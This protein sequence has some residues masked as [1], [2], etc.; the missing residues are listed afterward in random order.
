MVVIPTRPPSQETATEGEHAGTRSAGGATV[1]LV[2]G[3]IIVIIGVTL[4]FDYYDFVPVSLVFSQFGRLALPIIFILIGGALL[5]GRERKVQQKG[6]NEAEG[7]GESVD[8]GVEKKRLTRSIKDRKLAGVCG[9]LAAY[10][11]VD[12]TIVR[13]VYVILA[14]ASFGIALILYVVCAFIIPKEVN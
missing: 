9:G 2:V 1:T 8:S 10:L 13:F 3:I 12:P 4:L 11:D 14:F 6:E 5:L 7:A